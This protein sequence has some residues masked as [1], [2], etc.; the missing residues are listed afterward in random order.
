MKRNFAA[1][2]FSLLMLAAPA[3]A[4]DA[5]SSASAASNSFRRNGTADA[6]ASYDGR[7]GF[8]R[9]QSRS[10]A[11]NAARGV[12]VG[13]DKNGLSLSVSNAVA[14]RLGPAV[15]TNF[16]VSIGR[17][18]EVSHSGGISVA[19]SPIKR[20]VTAGGATGTGFRTPTATSFAS[21]KTDR[22]GRVDAH[23]NAATHAVA[24][25]PAAVVKHAVVKAGVRLM[26]ARR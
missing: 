25:R 4:S 8:A 9:T 16:N 5:E 15:A 10:G 23:T 18:G 7:V 11:V 20:S 12:A 26:R 13:V 24:V 1:Y 19:D 6:S 2:A 17:D 3:L 22:F 21:G 14:P